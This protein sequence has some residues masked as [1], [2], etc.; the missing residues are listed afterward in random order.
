MLCDLRQIPEC[1]KSSS[2][3]LR[4]K[5]KTQFQRYLTEVA[6]LITT[7]GHSRS[8]LKDY[9]LASQKPNCLKHKRIYVKK[10][11]KIPQVMNMEHFL[12]RSDHI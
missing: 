9:S 5:K 12:V 3:T 2:E 6:R 10:V 8:P 4:Q 7:S 11:L 1:D